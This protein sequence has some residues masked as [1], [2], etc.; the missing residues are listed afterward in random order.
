M[1]LPRLGF[2]GTGWIGRHRLQAIAQSGAA[3]IAA[4]VDPSEECAREA[5]ALAPGAAILSCY[6]SLL[7]A[8]LDG[9]VIA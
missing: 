3:E 6:E 1:T 5:Q 8:G 2:V 4:I 9:L 7:D